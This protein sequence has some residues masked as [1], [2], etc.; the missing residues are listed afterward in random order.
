MLL[1]IYLSIDDIILCDQVMPDVNG[2]LDHMQQFS[3]VR[4]VVINIMSMC[5]WCLLSIYTECT[6]WILEG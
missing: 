5:S 6:K 4:T 2:V 1:F 3:E